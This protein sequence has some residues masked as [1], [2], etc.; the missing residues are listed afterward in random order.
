MHA[1]LVPWNRRRAIATVSRSPGTSPCGHS[2]GSA[3][4]E[5]CDRRG[6]RRRQWLCG[7]GGRRVGSA[8]R[9]CRD[10]DGDSPKRAGTDCGT[11]RWCEVRGRGAG[12]AEP[13]GS[14]PVD[15]T[16]RA[17]VVAGRGAGA[18]AKVVTCAPWFCCGCQC[19][20]TCFERRPQTNEVG[21]YT[22]AGP[23][24]N[25][26][27]LSTCG[28]P[29]DLRVKTTRPSLERL[30]T[31]TIWKGE[32]ILGAAVAASPLPRGQLRKQLERENAQAVRTESVGIWTLGTKF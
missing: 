22:S 30:A 11:S 1:D 8:R 17:L 16:G 7:C 4:S 15:G 23:T 2:H 3:S 20:D 31:G 18:M 29:S 25:R 5:G 21:A 12:L 9:R 32:G 13:S 24:P 6:D 10:G 26:R 27:S 28:S 14:M 19:R